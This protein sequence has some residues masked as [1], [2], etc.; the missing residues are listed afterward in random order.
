M[1][2]WELASV[3]RADRITEGAAKAT[4][5]R[6]AYAEACITSRTLLSNGDAASA[7]ATLEPVVAE[8]IAAID[9]HRLLGIALLENGE[10]SRARRP[11]EIALE[12][13]PND[14]VAQVG[15][16]EVE[17]ATEGSAVAFR[18]WRRAWEIEPGFEPV[19]ARLRDIRRAQ[20]AEGSVTA[21]FTTDG[22]IDGPIAHTH[23]SLARARL[24]AGLHHHAM[25]DAME[26][27]RQDRS[28]VDIQLL[29][30][31]AWWRSGESEVA[32]D[33]AAAILEV[34]PNCVA[35][36]LLVAVHRRSVSRD[37][38]QQ[39]ERA[40]QADPFDRIAHQLF[41][42]RDV[43][44]IM[45]DAWGGDQWS[46]SRASYGEWP[47]VA[48]M[49]R[50]VAVVRAQLAAEK[51]AAEAAEQARLEAE[52]EARR[53]KAAEEAAKKPAAGAFKGTGVISDTPPKPGGEKGDSA[54]G[55]AAPPKPSG[56]K[57][58][59]VIA[60]EEPV[61]KSK[62]RRPPGPPPGAESAAAAT[63]AA[64]SA[65]S[66]PSPAA[67]DSS[68]AAHSPAPAPD[69]SASAPP[70]AEANVG[71]TPTSAAP[72]T[73]E[74]STGV[75]LPTPS[76]T[77][78]DHAPPPTAQPGPGTPTDSVPPAEP[79]TAPSTPVPV[80]ETPLPSEAAP[81]P[82]SAQIATQAVG[83]AHAAHLNVPDQREV[84]ASPGGPTEIATY[85]P[86]PPTIEVPAP[87]SEEPPA[88]V[89]I[90]IAVAKVAVVASGAGNRFDT[91]D[92]ATVRAL[93][94]AAFHDRR[95]TDAVRAYA[96]LLRRK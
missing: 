35:A 56:F 33:V 90:A 61:F 37:P 64:A 85:A 43:P 62:S 68:P 8:S 46:A 82:T 88:H 21:P 54:D 76:A 58:I 53:R 47:L 93:A 26:A 20:L 67:S 74:A 9:A 73:P 18:A 7:I 96:A 83:W 32:H 1:A 94:D 81:P 30:A 12:G 34:A 66:D 91:E 10:A 89:E 59:G 48:V 86:P 15:I 70:A 75:A 57:G 55:G 50:A 92:S 16:A 69:S 72:P 52:A 36:N 95:F 84:Q 2:W 44:P 60:E 27:L 40:R 11:F 25:L 45:D 3:S 80:A 42:G 4:G 24:R 17:E 29:L 6:R 5:A 77:S 49:P 39:V 22:S 38:R 41:A 31:E 78:D 28:R 65:A 13:D 23:P 51:A 71:T 19:S 63:V 79:V 14:L 87:R